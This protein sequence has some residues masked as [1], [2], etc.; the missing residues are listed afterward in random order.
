VAVRE[1]PGVFSCPGGAERGCVQV[2]VRQVKMFFEPCWTD[3]TRSNNAAHRLV[4]GG[5]ELRRRIGLGLE[6]G[7]FGFELADAFL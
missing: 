2:R 5:Y 3:S 4:C 1:E 6:F 7:D